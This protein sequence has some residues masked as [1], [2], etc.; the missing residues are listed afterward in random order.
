MEGGGVQAKVLIDGIATRALAVET[1]GLVVEGGLFYPSF[2]WL[3]SI[4]PFFVMTP[5]SSIFS[6]RFHSCL[7]FVEVVSCAVAFNG[8]L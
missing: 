5:L 3:Y 6:F 7:F 2:L 4:L 8:G 1:D